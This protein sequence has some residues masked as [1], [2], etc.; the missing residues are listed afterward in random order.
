MTEPTKNAILDTDFISKANIIQSGNSV[1][2]DEV[3]SFPGY[4]FFCHQKMVEELGDHGTRPSQEWLAKKIAA[5]MIDSYSDERIIREMREQTG[6][7]CFS[8]YRSFLKNGCDLFHRDFYPS[9]FEALDR[10]L[11]SGNLTGKA[12]LSVLQTCEGTIGHQE[13]YGE[14]KAFVLSQAL[15]LLKGTDTYIFCSDDFGAR[16]GF[17]NGALIPCI[18]ILGVFLKMKLMGKSMEEVQPFF[19]SFV[20]WCTERENPQTHVRV[21]EFASGSDKRVRVPIS[22]LLTEIFDGKYQAR[23]DGDLQ[24]VK[25]ENTTA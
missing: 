25:N 9:H 18:S 7:N 12:F 20:R 23:K 3:L 6:N 21:W 10:Y 15:K 17:A 5:G 24:M 4:R 8:Y 16:Q 1:L 2:A 13:S 22:T 11:E 14:I 19:H